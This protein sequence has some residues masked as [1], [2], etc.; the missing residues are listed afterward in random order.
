[1]LPVLLI[2]TFSHAGLPSLSGVASAQAPDVAALVQQ[3]SAAVNRRDAV[4]AAALFSDDANYTAYGPCQGGCKDR[5]E[6]EDAI[7]SAKLPVQPETYSIEQTCGD[8]VAV[9]VQNTEIR[10]NSYALETFRASGGRLTA[11]IRDPRYTLTLIEARAAAADVCAGAKPL[12]LP[13]DATAAQDPDNATV[14]ARFFDRINHGDSRGAAALFSD[15]GTYKGYGPCYNTCPERGEIQAGLAQ[16]WRPNA[17]YSVTIAQVCGDTMAV[18]TLPAARVPANPDASLWNVMIFGISAGRI[19]SLQRVETPIGLKLNDAH[20]A[21]APA[22]G[23][24]APAS[25]SP[26]NKGGVLPLETH[27]TLVMSTMLLGVVA[28][29]LIALLLHI[30]R[31]FTS[32]T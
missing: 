30:T 12:V 20:A 14:L 31:R 32:R 11:H 26:F 28:A 24:Q 16:D 15:A 29:V 27:L 4:A 5:A 1:V 9:L 2:L 3:F 23:A 10:G 21:A 17:P 19:A 7:T 18:L 22:C 13:A 6:I 25:P 8:T